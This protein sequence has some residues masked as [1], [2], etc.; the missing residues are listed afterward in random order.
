M[1]E[2]QSSLVPG[3]CCQTDKRPKKS[4]LPVFA[5]SCSRDASL[6]PAGAWGFQ[7]LASW[8]IRFQSSIIS[9]LFYS[10]SCFS[11]L[12]AWKMPPT[13]PT[14][15]HTHTTNPYTLCIPYSCWNPKLPSPSCPF[16]FNPVSFLLST[17]FFFSI[18]D[19]LEC[20]SPFSELFLLSG[21]RVCMLFFTSSRISFKTWHGQLKKIKRAWALPFCLITYLLQGLAY[22]KI[23]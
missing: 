7:S 10:N 23:Q 8:D 2:D 22:N 21:Y 15:P 1:R 19:L 12:L 9:P 13:H 17:L 20:I 6:L 3:C 14:P 18:L 4:Y 16:S 11:L 5:K